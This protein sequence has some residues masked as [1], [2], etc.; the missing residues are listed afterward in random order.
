MCHYL[1]YLR[2]GKAP[3][4]VVPGA[5]LTIYERV[6]FRMPLAVHG[7]RQQPVEG[8]HPQVVREYLLWFCQSKPVII[9]RVFTSVA[10]RLA[11]AESRG[12]GMIQ[13]RNAHVGRRRERIAIGRKV[14]H[15]HILLKQRANAI[16]GTL[17]TSR[18][19]AQHTVVAVYQESVVASLGSRLTNDDGAFSHLDVG[20][21]WQLRARCLA[22]KAL[23]QLCGSAIVFI[24]DRKRYARRGLAVFHEGCLCR[25]LRRSKRHD[26]Q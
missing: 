12:L 7:C 24:V 10:L 26:R 17:A 16:D 4:A 13:G 11:I 25:G 2:I 14:V 6:V 23:K 19:Y 21:D 1:E 8:M 20:H 3:L 5:S 15:A 9:N 18:L 22:H